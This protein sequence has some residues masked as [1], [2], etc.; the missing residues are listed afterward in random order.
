MVRAGTD[1]VMSRHQLSGE[2]GTDGVVRAG[3]DG[4]VRA[5]TDGVVRTG[6]DGGT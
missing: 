4:V 2:R 3:T 5:G 6:T 1:G